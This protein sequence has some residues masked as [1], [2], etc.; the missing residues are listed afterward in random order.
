MDLPATMAS[1]MTVCNVGGAS[2]AP[3]SAMEILQI[4]F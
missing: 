3:K 1:A 2:V 4:Q